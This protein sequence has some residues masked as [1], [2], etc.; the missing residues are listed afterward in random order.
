MSSKVEQAFEKMTK[1]IFLLILPYPTLTSFFHH[2]L[3]NFKKNI[4]YLKSSINLCD[5]YHFL[6]INNCHKSGEKIDFSEKFNFP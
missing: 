2:F 1:Y 5:E 4:S 6:H 3:I